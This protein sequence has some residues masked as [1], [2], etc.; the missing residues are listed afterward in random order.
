MLEQI[1]GEQALENVVIVITGW[2]QIPNTHRDAKEAELAC[3]F[4]S[5]RPNQFMRH[6]GTRFS[7]LNVMSSV[8]KM[9]SRPLRIQIELE[10]TKDPA[11]TSAGMELFEDIRRYITAKQMEDTRI[12][13]E[14]GA[15]RRATDKDKVTELNATLAELGVVLNRLNGEQSKLEAHV[16]W[17]QAARDNIALEGAIKKQRDLATKDWKVEYDK[18][19]IEHHKLKDELVRALKPISGQILNSIL[20]CQEKYRKIHDLRLWYPMR[21]TITRG[22]PPLSVPSH[23]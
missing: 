13:K 22:G 19:M 16:D 12:R 17:E 23:R 10:V 11:Y 2:D 7:A 3:L 15:A 4:M 1:V 14:I 8:L 9:T 18:L 20:Q 5:F 21:A 6:D